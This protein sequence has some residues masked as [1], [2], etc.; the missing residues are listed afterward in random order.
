MPLTS[1]LIGWMAGG[2]LTGALLTNGN[3]RDH[4]AFKQFSCY[5]LQVRVLRYPGRHLPVLLC[6]FPP[7][8]PTERAVRGVGRY[9]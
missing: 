4:E 6:P 7:Y 8:V 3:P 5:V 1:D 9:L 2:K